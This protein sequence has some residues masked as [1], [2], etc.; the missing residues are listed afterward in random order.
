MSEVL[1]ICGALV[2]T[3]QVIGISPL[4]IIKAGNGDRVKVSFVLI[5]RNHA[6]RIELGEVEKPD[7]HYLTLSPTSKEY[8]KAI[9]ESILYESIL[10]EYS[11][12]KQQIENIIKL[13]A[14]HEI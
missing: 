14:A 1:T 9:M 7:L 6:P 13:R 3:S 2:Q 12:G 8:Q 4:E 10:K 5:L 11:K